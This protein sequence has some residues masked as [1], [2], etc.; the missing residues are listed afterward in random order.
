M[1]V[2]S[3]YMHRMRPHHHSVLWIVAELPN[4]QIAKLDNLIIRNVFHFKSPAHAIMVTLD[5]SELVVVIDAAILN[6]ER[7]AAN[8]GT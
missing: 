4:L 7:R 6:H 5:V 3:I 2:K 8:S 1:D